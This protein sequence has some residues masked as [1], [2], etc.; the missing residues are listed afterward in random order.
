MTTT[1]NLPPS[2]PAPKA[3]DEKLI[4]PQQMALSL[5]AVAAS[6]VGG[7]YTTVRRE[8][9]KMKN[10]VGAGTP[11]VVASKALLY[12]SAYSIGGFFLGTSAIVMF[13]GVSSFQEFGEYVDKNFRT[14]EGYRRVLEKRERER[15]QLEALSVKYAHL[16]KYD[17]LW[18]QLRANE[19]LE[20]D[21]DDEDEEIISNPEERERLKLVRQERDDKTPD[22]EHYNVVLVALQNLKKV[23][24]NI[25]FKFF[26][27]PLPVES[28]NNT[29]EKKAGAASSSSLAAS[30]SNTRNSD[31]R[32]ATGSGATKG[33][34]EED[35]SQNLLVR[36][37]NKLT[38]ILTSD[39]SPVAS[40]KDDGAS[41]TPQ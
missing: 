35:I 18:K 22:P 31:K 39:T 15:L 33:K 2:K 12:G 8:K 25:G 13:T 9:L 1:E 6:M 23:I 41:D 19:E 34:F 4:G 11:A 37:W 21:E 29:D 3:S 7:V 38:T 16:S 5:F 10:I 14:E 28:S 40:D 32:V 26:D 36:K 30:A 24:G 27:I 17:L 20:N